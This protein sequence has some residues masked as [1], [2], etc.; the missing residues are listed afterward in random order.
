LASTAFDVEDASVAELGAD[1]GRAE[2][3][4]LPEFDLVGNANGGGLAED[5]DEDVVDV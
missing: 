4:G 5:E 2:D 1:S 3:E